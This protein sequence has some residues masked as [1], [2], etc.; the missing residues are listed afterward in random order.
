[1]KNYLTIFNRTASN[2]LA[3]ST[4][5]SKRS[6]PLADLLAVGFDWEILFAQKYTLKEFKEHTSCYNK[7]N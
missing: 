6:F 1:M 7:G 5:F 2:S 3:L 4:L